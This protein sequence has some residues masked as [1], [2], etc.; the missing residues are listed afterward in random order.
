MSAHGS[1]HSPA[2]Y[3]DKSGSAF[4][5]WAT[6][7]GSHQGFGIAAAR[8]LGMASIIAQT[9]PRVKPLG[10]VVVGL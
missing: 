7:R 6:A 3:L 1:M 5:T 2:C 9:G 4:P 10:L 8:E